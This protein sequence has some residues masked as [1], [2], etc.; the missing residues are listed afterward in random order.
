MDIPGLKP[1]II[2]YNISHLHVKVVVNNLSDHLFNHSIYW[3]IENWP[4]AD[5]SHPGG[6]AIISKGPLVLSSC[7]ALREIGINQLVKIKTYDIYL[8]LPWKCIY[9]RNLSSSPKVITVQ[10]CSKVAEGKTISNKLP[11]LTEFKHLF[12]QQY[13]ELF[14]RDK[15]QTSIYCLL[16]P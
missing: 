14:L 3:N 16:A 12:R 11:S 10:N 7:G 1:R 6:W 2:Q 5:F 4:K 9:G 15:I 13:Q 8:M